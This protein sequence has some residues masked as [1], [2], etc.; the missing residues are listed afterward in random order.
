M[1]TLRNHAKNPKLPIILLSSR[2]FSFDVEQYLR[3]G[4]DKCFAK[5]VELQELA[6][7]CGVLSGASIPR[8]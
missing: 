7:T 1:T 3:A 8:R 6:R 4:V 5:P 2:A